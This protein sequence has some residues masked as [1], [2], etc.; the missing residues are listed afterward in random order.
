MTEFDIRELLDDY[1]DNG[2]AIR[3]KDA[4]SVTTVKE[5]VMKR[6]E[7]P[8]PRRHKS[9]WPALVAAVLCVT[10]LTATAFAAGVFKLGE[11][12]VE[13][14][15]ASAPSDKYVTAVSTEEIYETSDLP[16]VSAIGFVNSKEYLAAQ[17]WETYLES[18]AADGT[19]QLTVD[20]ETFQADGYVW[21]NA[22][23]P[24]ARAALDEIL[25]T[26]GL[27][28]PSY[29]ED[30]T[31]KDLYDLTGETDILPLDADRNLYAVSGRYFEGGALQIVNQAGIRDGL[32]VSYDLYRSVKGWFSRDVRIFTELDTME[33]WSYTTADSTVVILAM[34]E[35][36]SV[37]MAELENSFIYVHIRSGSEN[38]DPS[39]GSYG[40][41][42]VEKADLEAFADSINFTALDSIK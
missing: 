31:G 33:E 11:R 42:T 24:Q 41:P 1:T 17:E 2:I 15:A 6:I 9:P 3:T 32:T 39:R 5:D 30:V 8:T 36:Q 19:N 23:S 28:L 22:F 38:T 20:P 26:Y 40:C 10:L 21:A 34:G 12:Q 18:S 13:D 7:K 25:E 4:V 37:L 27:A 16:S 14:T 29:E 35:N